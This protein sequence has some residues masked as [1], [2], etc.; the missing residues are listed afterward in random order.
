M[1]LDDFWIDD[2]FAPSGQRFNLTLLQEL[3]R[4]PARQ[5]TDL[6]AAIALGRLALTEFLKAGTDSSQQL[7]DAQSREVVRGLVAL[8]DRLGIKFEP[9]FRDFTGFKAYWGSHGGYGSWA[10]RR[11]M[12]NEVFGALV[13]ELERREDDALRGELVESLSESGRTGWMVVD[14]EIAELR[15]HFHAARTPQD[16]RNIGNDVVAVLEALSA[17]AY[18]PHR[19][20]FEGETEPPVAQTKNRLGRVVAVDSEPEGSDELTR[21]AKATV[22]LAQAVKHNPAGSRVRAAIAA[23]AVIQ[24]ADIVRRLQE[25]YRT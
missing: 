2:E 5:Y 13:E 24:L 3:R 19:H 22:E 16:F 9:P 23:N 18:Y 4:G 7:T 21:L 11:T 6:E 14:D 25:E 1:R 15:R 10:A 8:S 20:L 17:V 12:V